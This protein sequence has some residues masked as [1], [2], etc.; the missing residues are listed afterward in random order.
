MKRAIEEDFP[1]TE[2]NRLSIPERSSFKPIYQMHK[3]FARRASCVFRAI[4]LG[5][6]KPTGTNI[7]EEFYKDHSQDADTNGKVVLDPFMGGGT[8]VVE[9][10]RLGCKPIGIDLNPVS[11]FIVKTQV[12]P[13]DLAK[14]ESAFERLTTSIVPWSGK[15]LRETLLSL[16]RSAAPWAMEGSPSLPDSDIIYTFWVKSAICTSASCRKLIPLFSDYVVAAKSPSIFYHADC[17]CSKCKKTFDWEIEP[18]ALVGDPRLM[19]HSAA[20][21]AGAGRTNT[22]WTYAHP[23][24]GLYVCQGSG[25]E[26]QGV[27]KLGVLEKSHV[28]CPHCQEIVKPVLPKTK[29][30]R[31]KVPLTVLLCPKT[32]EVFQ[33]RGELPATG[34]LIKSPAGHSFDPAKGNVTG[35]GEFLCPHC[36]RTDKIIESIRGLPEDRL[37]PMDAYAMQVY[38]PGCDPT[39]DPVKRE[40]GQTHFLSTDGDGETTDDE[41]AEGATT[42]VNYSGLYVPPTHNLVWKQKGKYYTRFAPVDEANF[43]KAEALWEKHRVSLP[44]PKSEVPEGEKTKSGLIAHHYR[45]WH[46]M[47]NPRQLLALSTLLE[48]ISKVGNQKLRDLFLCAFSNTLEANNVFTRNIP[49]RKTPGGTAPAGVFARHD[50]QPKMTFCEQNVWG[51]VSGNN[52]YISRIGALRLGLAYAET[53]YDGDF[54]EDGKHCK[55]E[56]LDPIQP[57]KEHLIFAG[58]SREEIRQVGKADV[59]ITDPPYADNVNYAELADFFYVWLRLIF[60]NEDQKFAPEYCSKINEIVENRSRGLSMQDFESGL[61]EVFT[62]A[63]EKI[64]EDGLVIFTF[65]HAEGSSWESVLNSICNA[66][67][68]IEAIYPVHSEREVSLHL[69]DN[70]AIAYDLIH[71][72]RK[73][74]PEDVAKPRSWAGL[75]Q[76]VRSRAREEVVRIE[77]GR[78]GRDPL[79]APDVRMVLIGKCLDVYSRHF[80]TVL[81][82]NGAPYPLRS[83]LQDI[84]LMVE[85][86]V[87]KENP[88]PGQLEG[89][90][91]L[92]QVWLLALCDKRE[93]SVDSISKMTRGIFEVG[94]LTGHKPPLLRKGRVKGGRTYEVLSPSE[95]LDKLREV[96]AETNAKTAE[97][98]LDLPVSLALEAPLVDVL[99]LL[100]AEAEAGERLDLLVDRFR[101]RKEAVQAALEFLQQR[102]PNRWGKACGKL[103]PF[104]SDML[105]QQMTRGEG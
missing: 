81:D 84:R 62:K 91:A 56:G 41:N 36:G 100:L 29:K 64:A 33:W 83:A 53:P 94:D 39:N 58:D 5:A 26:G 47:F 16:Y 7:M 40:E 25:T 75:R 60:K 67:M 96:L 17:T 69:Q 66:G 6:L 2:I 13:V 105:A 65:H 85:Q 24:G 10:L 103:L 72:C 14:F 11:W 61:T 74:R 87:S 52:T 48:C 19:L 89:T 3:W 8:T 42:D 101:G 20:Y 82:W 35:K 43:Q 59:V 44:H 78:Y 104:Y 32:E 57:D 30:K 99:H 21:S 88:L 71:V 80:G 49:S 68:L 27:V 51:T 77:A 38:S 45:Y 31:K 23:E 9:A 102:D 92:S 12:E 90:D 63:S 15:S 93:V 54:D 73:R 18:A 28:C 86:V 76:E 4:L 79:P 50:F 34:T 97:L 95:R 37:L 55:R 70:E 98:P 46:Q 22:R 1:I